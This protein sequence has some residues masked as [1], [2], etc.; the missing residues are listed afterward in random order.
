MASVKAE[1]Y[2]SYRR[3]T[4]DLQKWVQTHKNDK[5]NPTV[6]G[7]DGAIWTPFQ[8]L[9][10]DAEGDLAKALGWARR[11]HRVLMEMGV[12]LDAPRWFFSG[13]KGF[14]CELPEALFGG[15]LPGQP[16]SAT[17]SKRSHHPR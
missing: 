16:P 12:D 6:A 7:F 5:G 15:F 3:A 1:Q 14:H 10:F 17:Q 4:I 9:D 13:Y 2:H 11:T 8:H